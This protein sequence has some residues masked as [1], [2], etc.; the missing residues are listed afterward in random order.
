MNRIRRF[1]LLVVLF[2]LGTQ[3]GAGEERSGRAAVR[4]YNYAEV[5]PEVLRRAEAETARVFR[6][7]GVELQWIEFDMSGAA[8]KAPV[9][10]S[11]VPVYNLRLLSKSMAGRLP[12]PARKFG[13]ALQ[14][15]AFLFVHRIR[16][17]AR[18]SGFPLPLV[19]GHIMAHELG[20]LLLGENS[21]STAG[22]MSETL[23]QGEFERAAMGGLLFANDEARRMRSR[24]ISSAPPEGSAS[25]PAGAG[26]W[27][28]A[29]AASPLP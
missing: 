23:R 14:I 3:V 25:A 7:A 6:Q 5:D 12:R 18:D 26:Y 19:L 10:P 1:S 15:D 20:H 2:L 28:A 29:P 17:L 16:D 21:H 24:P 11:D 27:D 4:I 22:I 13:I 8:D 9:V